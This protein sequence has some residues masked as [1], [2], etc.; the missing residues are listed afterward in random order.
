[1]EF[2][3]LD[4]L[5]KDMILH[6]IL[7]ALS[8]DDFFSG[9][10]AFKGGTC[11]IKSYLGYFRFSEDIDFT[12][13]NQETFDGKSQNRIRKYLSERIEKTGKVFESLGQAQGFEFVIDK[14]NEMYV[15]LRGSNKFATFKLWYDS[16]ILSYTN[17]IKVQFNFV[18]LLKY[19]IIENK[20]NSVISDL[21]SYELKKF[22]PKEYEIY[23]N[24]INFI[25]K[26]IDELE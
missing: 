1:M 6:D 9:N 12:W 17:F 25:I 20:L 2:P 22:F 5:E 15:D 13:Q 26:I 4:L 24:K 10:F 16:E 11:L 18:E 14:G 8:K 7:S 21:S 19:P 23:S 3:R